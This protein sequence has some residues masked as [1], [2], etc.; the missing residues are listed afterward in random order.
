[1]RVLIA[2]VGNILRSDDGFGPKVIEEL[3]K[4]DLPSG[5][6]P[7]DYGSS[8][9]KLL[10][11][12][13]DY[14][15]AIFVDTV[16]RGGK[17]GEIFVI[18]PS[19][20]QLEY[21]K[22]TVKISLHESNLEKLLAIAKTLKVLPREVIIVGC[23]PKNLSEGLEMSEEVRRAVEKAVEIILGILGEKKICLDRA[24]RVR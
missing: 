1:M 16:D 20:N 22:S 2:G 6:D 12:L 10:L 21:E 5:V 4:Y 7:V 9:F 3:I 8:I 23:Q 19:L 18:K 15:L 14:D 11:D 17:P 13:K 24:P